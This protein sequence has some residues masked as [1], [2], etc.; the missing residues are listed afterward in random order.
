MTDIFKLKLMDDI[1]KSY[2]RNNLVVNTLVGISLCIAIFWLISYI[3][4]EVADEYSSCYFF[5]NDYYMEDVNTIFLYAILLPLGIVTLMLLYD[6][7]RPSIKS[8]MNTDEIRKRQIRYYCLSIPFILLSLIIIVLSIALHNAN[9]QNDELMTE[10]EDRDSQIEELKKQI[11]DQELQIS[12]L[13]NY[14]TNLQ[15]QA[16]NAANAAARAR[17]NLQDA[18][19]WAQSGNAF[20]S[21]NS[22]NNAKRELNNW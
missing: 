1:Q 18:E 5:T 4:H 17:Q 2:K 15:N 10:I 8:E 7:L 13:R 6:V 20:Q 21:N 3:Y 22:Y 9:A 11:E 16:N 19:F 12:A 14:V